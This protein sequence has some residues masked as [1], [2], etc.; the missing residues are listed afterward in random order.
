M[1]LLYERGINLPTRSLSLVDRVL[2][3]L[4]TLVCLALSVYWSITNFNDWQNKLTITTV[5][6]KHQQ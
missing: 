1:L 6:V 3:T 2:W 5:K 4:V